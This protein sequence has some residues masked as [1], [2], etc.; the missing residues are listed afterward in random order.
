M[1]SIDIALLLTDPPGNLSYHLTIAMA[2]GVILSLALIYRTKLSDSIAQRC[3]V[4]SGTLLAF[5]LIFLLIDGLIWFD[6]MKMNNFVAAMDR[7]VILLS[8]LAFTWLLDLPTPKYSRLFLIAG[9]VLTLL[10][11]VAS[12]RLIR[13]PS[14]SDP[15]NDTGFDIAWS[16]ISLI[17]TLFGAIALVTLR[18]TGWDFTVSPFALM[19]IGVL[20]HIAYGP[21]TTFAAGFVRYA[22]I[23][24][25]PLFAALIAKALASA[26]SDIVFEA[27]ELFREPSSLEVTTLTV[28]ISDLTRL[29]TSTDQ[30][31]LTKSAVEIIAKRMNSDYCLLIIPSENE[32][33]LVIAAGF[34]LFQ[35]RHLP[36]TSISS[37]NLPLIMDA[38]RH[39][40][41]L[42]T[43]K[44]LSAHELR[45]LQPIIGQGITGPTLFV[46]ISSGKRVLGG[47]LLVSH[48]S[49]QLWSSKD[50]ETMELIAT[51]LF[52]RF[53]ELK[54]SEDRADRR[55][56]HEQKMQSAQRIKALEQEK[57]NLEEALEAY[58]SREASIPH[59][60][61]QSLL[62]MHENDQQEIDE[63]KS[64][65]QELKANLE[66]IVQHSESVALEQVMGE[67]LVALQELAETRQS[68]STIEQQ[69]TVSPTTR[70]GPTPDVEAIISI[71]Q[72]LR[73]PMASIFSY[74]ELLLSESVGILGAMQQK[75]L[76]RIHNA[77]DR[78]GTLLNNLIRVSAGEVKTLSFAPGPVEVMHCLENAIA[79]IQNKIQ[80]KN[81]TFRMDIP[82]DPFTLLADEDGVIQIFHHLLDNAIGAS[83]EEGEVVIIIR[84]QQAEPNNYLMI[85]VADS[86]EGIQSEDIPQVFQRTYSGDKVTIQ[87]VSDEGIGLSVVKSISE[88]LGGR[89]WVDSE[90]GAGSIFT[91]LLP[92][93]NK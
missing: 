84:E 17:V 73:Q 39:G 86:G 49:R 54:R 42:I 89:V 50:R 10:I 80:Q 81:I 62:N 63:L 64:E 56:E 92:L 83:P 91:V 34:D 32:E 28:A 20:L 25:Y 41:S 29:V 60:D 9:L 48:S 3:M 72:E 57:R 23:A 4:I 71:A 19:S 37:K 46:P 33:K 70:V 35:D 14:G 47:F 44:E 13:G 79:Q 2:L 45:A 22:E 90:V 26:Q 15:L 82:D 66:A 78:M 75:F 87:G 67:R 5:R 88:N 76:E 85:S 65:I 1:S 16:F 36:H 38:L 11:F 43:Q 58:Q 74:T 59:E 61:L 6:V 77:S 8:L 52:Q 68:L 69:I 30:T 27:K 93:A 31:H 51:L 21:K 24:A 7:F 55:E 40:K 53:Q 18:P 12:P